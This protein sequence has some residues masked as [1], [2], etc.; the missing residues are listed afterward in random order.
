MRFKNFK[1]LNEKSH[2]M[3]DDDFNGD[4]IYNINITPEGKLPLGDIFT[5]KEIVIYIGNYDSY[6]ENDD[7][8]K[9][10]SFRPYAF[11]Y[12]METYG[13]MKIYGS[14]DEYLGNVHGGVGPKVEKQFYD[15]DFYDLRKTNKRQ[16][17]DIKEWFSK[18]NWHIIDI[19]ISKK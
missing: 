4:D 1:Q 8:Y 11:E 2:H 13:D 15:V 7:E 9:V 3:K 5:E 17:E 18:T 14:F 12:G 16:Y 10:L 6:H 19:F